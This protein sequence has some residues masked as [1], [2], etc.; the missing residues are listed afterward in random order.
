MVIE[1]KVKTSS[2]KVCIEERDNIYFVSLKSKPY[3]NSAN[4]ELID[5]LSSYFNVPKSSVNISYGFRNK[6]KL[7][8]ILD[9]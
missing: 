7:I 9:I 6:R 1:V 8:E 4:L 5:V 2:K 3:K